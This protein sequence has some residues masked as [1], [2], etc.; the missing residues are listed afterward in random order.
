MKLHYFG[1][2]GRGEQIRMLLSH[3][4]VPYENVEYTHET[5]DEFKKT[6]NLEFGQVPVLEYEGKFYAQS[7]SILRFLGKKYGY[8]PE[9]A[10]YAWR[11]DST[12][13]SL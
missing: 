4:K 1:G 6:G 5:L 13:D 2:Y 11:V 10:H 8:Y 12:I 3:A 7:V 9:D